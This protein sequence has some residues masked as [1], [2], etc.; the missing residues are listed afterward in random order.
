MSK[1]RDSRLFEIGIPDEEEEEE[2]TVLVTALG[3]VICL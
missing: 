3:I 1:P 2:E